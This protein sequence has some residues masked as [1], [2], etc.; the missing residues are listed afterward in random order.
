[1]A[2]FR[3]YCKLLS[4]YKE[5]YTIIYGNSNAKDSKMRA[6][7]ILR[8]FGKEINNNDKYLLDFST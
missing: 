7:D 8:T 6:Q 1:L 2:H 3:K 5:N 4:K